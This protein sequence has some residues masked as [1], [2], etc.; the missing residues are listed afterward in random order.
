MAAVV[1]ATTKVPKPD[2]KQV[3]IDSVRGHAQ[4]SQVRV[5]AILGRHAGTCYNL[6]LKIEGAADKVQKYIESMTIALGPCARWGYT[7][8]EFEVFVLEDR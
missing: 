2:Y 3:F 5:T 8:D 6:G 1:I 4:D 7:E